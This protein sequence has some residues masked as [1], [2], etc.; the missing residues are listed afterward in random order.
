MA[1]R[2]LGEL[3]RITPI[4]L[5]ILGNNDRGAP[6]TDMPDTGEGHVDHDH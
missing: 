6:L 1:K 2:L 3:K 4:F 5:W